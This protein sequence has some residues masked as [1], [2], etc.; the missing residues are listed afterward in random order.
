MEQEESLR[1]KQVAV[2]TNAD[3]SVLSESLSRLL[4]LVSNLVALS[5]LVDSASGIHPRHSSYYIRRVRG[6][7]DPFQL[8][9]TKR[10]T[11]RRLCDE[12]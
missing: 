2:K 1:T 8:L 6:D 12:A 11:Y 7:K 10:S 5:Q 9:K 4:S 3:L